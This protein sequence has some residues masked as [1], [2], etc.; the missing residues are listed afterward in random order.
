[1]LAVI[2]AILFA[3]ALLFNLTDTRLGSINVLDLE[4]AGLLFFALHFAAWRSGWRGRRQLAGAAAGSWPSRPATD[5]RSL[6]ASGP[7][8]T[9][10]VCNLARF[11]RGP[12]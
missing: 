11:E 9:W 2:A 3:L 12:I 10:P 7:F 8:V 6:V 5:R 4:L 1:M